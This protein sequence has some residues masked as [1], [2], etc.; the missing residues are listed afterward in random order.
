MKANS[1]R[2]EVIA[3]ITTFLTM[4]YIIFVNPLI[5]SSD[6]TGM[7]FSAVMTGTIL[8]SF[9]ATLLMGLIAKL[10]FALAPGMGLNAFFT[11]TL[12]L[13]QKIPWEQALGL[14]FW[15]GVV[16]VILSVTPF[17][18]KLVKSI[19]KNL[20]MAMA[21]GIGI[22]LAFIG[23][24]NT[25]IIIDHP[26]TLVQTAPLSSEGGAVIL[27]FVLI[28]ALFKKNIPGSLLIGIFFTWTLG[29]LFGK[30]TL[31]ENFFATPD[32]SYFM[33]ADILG[34]IKIAYIPSI[35]TLMMTDLFD[36]LST[37]IGVAETANLKNEKGEIKNMK[38]ALTVDALATLFS[39][40]F[41]TSTTTTFVESSAG[42]SVGGRTGLTSVITA[43]CFLPFLFLAP[44][45]QSIPSYATAPVLIF[46]GILMFKNISS[47]NF[48]K[49]EEMIPAFLCIVLIPLS[50][51]ITTG[52]MWGLFVH[53]ILYI[54]A[55]RIKD[56]SLTECLLSIV[57]GLYIIFH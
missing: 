52:I 47:I 20:R 5:L 11:Y 17:R 56:L 18:E 31:P 3:G 53:T 19:P 33:Q 49:F 15:S 39:A 16:F 23:L 45:A 51:S 32:F 22:F 30:S 54:V 57:A 28:I 21:V 12:I 9:V 42:V 14:V 46:V 36:S 48:E 27:G 26:V 37:F 41:G 6:G 40:F 50:F 25:G 24:K 7:S 38:Q 55:G 2:T 4:S 29:A 8:A 35:L 34:A 13:D 44:F 1:I 43:I 10:P